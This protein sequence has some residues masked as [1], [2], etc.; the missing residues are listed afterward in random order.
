MVGLLTRLWR[1]RSG[2]SLTEGII[3]FPV[4]FLAV[5]A[6][7]ELGVALFQY[8]QTAK[9]VQVGARLAAVSDPLISLAPMV[10]RYGT[11]QAGTAVPDDNFSISCGA[12]AA[13]CV[14][15]RLN[16]LVG[17]TNTSC[18]ARLETGVMGMCD[19]NPLIRSGNVRVTYQ[20]TGLG[21][22]GR[23][24]SPVVSVRVELV[25]LKFDFFLLGAL[26]GL[27]NLSIPSQAVTVTSEDL[28]T[29]PLGLA[30][31]GS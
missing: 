28:S 3:A 8:N 19:V 23:P 17:G 18:N 16:R 1:D 21:Y 4:I 5:C 31:G 9:A 22:V 6:F 29:P 24:Y 13:A 20:S 26:L 25:N 15:A 12:G 7:I 10:A 14:P 27:N 11:A 30:S 2:I